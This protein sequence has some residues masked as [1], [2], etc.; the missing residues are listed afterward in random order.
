MLSV[1]YCDLVCERCHRFARHIGAV[2]PYV[3]FG[4]AVHPFVK[5]AEHQIA[6]GL[7]L[8][9]QLVFMSES[10]ARESRACLDF[11]LARA[12]G[13]AWRTER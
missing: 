7:R 9:R 12:N 5:T 8:R 13:R 4:M 6:C 10:K 2:A 1:G 3:S 11:G